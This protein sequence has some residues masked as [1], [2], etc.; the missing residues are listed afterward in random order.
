MFST[1]ASQMAM[2]LENA[3]LYE[4]ATQ[5]QKASRASQEKLR[6]TFQFAMDG[7]AVTDLNGPITEVNKRAVQM[8]GD[9]LAF[10]S[11]KF[12]KLALLPNT[13]SY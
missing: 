11:V 13:T 5:S 7:I 12:A 4:E 10:C 9:I 2:V 3:R 8:R 1:I 6:L